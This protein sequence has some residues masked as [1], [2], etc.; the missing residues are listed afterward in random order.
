MPDSNFELYGA[1]PRALRCCLRCEIWGLAPY[2]DPPHRPTEFGVINHRRRR[3]SAH[4]RRP[5]RSRGEC[6]RIADSGRRRP[7]SCPDRQL[8]RRIAERSWSTVVRS[9]FHPMALWPAEWPAMLASP[10]PGDS[11]HLSYR[12]VRAKSRRR[13]QPAASSIRSS[14]TGASSSAAA[15]PASSPSGL[16]TCTVFVRSSVANA[17]VLSPT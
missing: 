3:G 6:E 7:S 5:F 4:L 9:G 11:T 8:W 15:R 12:C 17:T 2:T 14:R 13:S 16:D 10:W 1:D